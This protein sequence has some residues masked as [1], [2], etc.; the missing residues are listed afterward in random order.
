MDVA[1]EIPP[2]WLQK[3]IE[4]S[5]KV[6]SSLD[7]PVV[8][9]EILEAACRIADAEGGSILLQEETGRR[10][11]FEAATG[12][13]GQSLEGRT[14]EPG[15]GIAGWVA[16]ERKPAIVGDT[17]ADRRF[18]ARI[19]RQTGFHTRSLV[20]V[21][22]EHPDRL[23]GV[24]E[25]VNKREGNFT[26]GDVE[27][28][29]ALG[30]LAAT[31]IL[32]AGRYG[33]AREARDLLEESVQRY[34]DLV[35]QSAAMQ[36]IF[37]LIERAA[38][39]R[40]TIFIHGE[41]GTGKE[42]IARAIHWKSPRRERPFVAVNCCA[43][44]ETL[45]ESELFGHERGSFTGALARKKGKFEVADGGTVF[46]DEVGDVS[47]ALQLKLLRVLQGRSFERVGGNETLHVDVRVIAATNRDLEAALQD[48]SFRQDLFFRLNVIPVL[49]PPLRER[50]DDIPLLAG[51]FLKKFNEEVKGR[52][53]G[54]TPE[55]LSALGAY[56]WPGN[57][58]ELENVVERAVVL[59]E[60]D[61]IDRADLP[62]EIAAGP[63]ADSEGGLEA[64]VRLFKRQRVMDALRRAN[65]N[66]T[67]AAA[68]LGIQRTYLFRLMRSL[69]IR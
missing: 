30:R 42:L 19:D 4:A 34:C 17:A 8:L 38:P 50:R 36:E 5:L 59:G 28:L 27:L 9:R 43:L 26:G 7:L 47:P 56:R 40:S 18:L 62:L 31:A 58:R 14:I 60:G 66:K 48:G 55:A 23:V 6:H 57:V 67:R 37:R 53:R 41:S 2:E 12:E 24:L 33:R 11:R 20:A 64:A 22:L 46:L 3:I 13:K 52:V 25:L 21:P 39:S 61:W 49:V 68:L 32:N 51:Y 63:A 45:L 29:Q 1:I 65:G 16:R 54:F 10:L 44:T 35:G 69:D 15:E